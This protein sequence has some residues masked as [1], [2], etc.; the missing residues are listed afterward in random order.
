MIKI[1]LRYSKVALWDIE[2]IAPSFSATSKTYLVLSTVS[3][4]RIAFRTDRRTRLEDPAIFKNNKKRFDLWIFFSYFSYK[5]LQSEFSYIHDEKKHRHH[6]VKFFD[7]G[8]F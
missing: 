2:H 7:M 3:Q 4:S 5:F 6:V 8:I 1:V